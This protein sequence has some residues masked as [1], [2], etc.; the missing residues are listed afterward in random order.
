[1]RARHAYSTEE[2]SRERSLRDFYREVV[3]IIE[4][5]MFEHTFDSMVLIAEPRLL[6]TIRSLLPTELQKLVRA[7][8]PKDL[9][10]EGPSEIVA[11]VSAVTPG[12]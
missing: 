8:V 5:A 1:M 4:R 6:G 10:Y 9:S 3:E 7:E 2:S 12:A 11:R